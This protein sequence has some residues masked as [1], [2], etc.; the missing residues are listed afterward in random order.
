MLLRKYLEGARVREVRHPRWERL[1]EIGCVHGQPPS[2]SPAD[3]GPRPVWIV[4][5]LMGRLSNLI[6]R[7]DDGMIL[8]AL[9]LVDATE[10]RYRTIAPHVLY[11][12]PPP[13]TRVVGQDVL[14]RLEPERVSADDLER[15]GEEMR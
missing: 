1:V 14:P 7:D 15:A 9:R 13:Q 5:E 12:Y 2:A 4:V 3:A 6:L 11:R 8:G 10:N